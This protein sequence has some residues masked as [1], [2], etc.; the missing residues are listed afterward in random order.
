MFYVYILKLSNGDHHVGFSDDLENRIRDHQAGKCFTMVKF[1]PIK[2][3]W[4]SAFQDKYKALE[5]ERY[6]KKG[7]GHAFRHRHL[8]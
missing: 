7:T 5:F 1:R 6:L 3:I 4:Y 2:L 8:E